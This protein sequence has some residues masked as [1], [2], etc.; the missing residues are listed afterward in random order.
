MCDP[1]EYVQDQALLSDLILIDNC[2]GLL[3]SYRM[4]RWDSGLRWIS[5][6]YRDSALLDDGAVPYP[7]VVALLESH[8]TIHG[9][10]WIL[11]ECGNRTDAANPEA[12]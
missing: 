3:W 4:N 1:V 12:L 9:G 2:T 5:L 7:S 10:I 6:T 8:M 11:A